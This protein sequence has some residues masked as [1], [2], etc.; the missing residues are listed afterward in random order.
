MSGASRKRKSLWD[1][2]TKEEPQIQAQVGEKNPWH[3]EESYSSL[4]PSWQGPQGNNGQKDDNRDL[5]DVV[6]TGR[7]C[8]GDKSYR[9]S[10]GFHAPGQQSLGYSHE[11]S[12]SQSHRYRR[13][14]S[15][16]LSKSRSRS[17]SSSRSRS[18][19]RGRDRSR[20]HS[21]GRSRDWGRGRSRSRSPLGDYRRESHRLNDNRSRFPPSSQLCRDYA[22]GKCRRGSQC[23]YLHQDNLNHKDGERLE[24]EQTDRWRSRQE[25]G[26][27]R[28]DGEKDEFLRNTGKPA[29]ICIDFLKGRCH[30]GSS[31]RYPHHDATGDNKDRSNKY[32]SSDHGYKRQPRKSTPCKYFLM[33][34]CQRDDC[35]FSHD[36]PAHGNLEGKPLDD[37]W[38]RDFDNMNKPL[39][40]S[41][42]GAPTSV[43][44]TA[45]N[46]GSGNTGKGSSITAEKYADNAWGHSLDENN[47]QW[48]GPKWSDVAG[49]SGSAKS[50]CWG[51]NNV[52][53]V[54]LTNLMNA[55]KH[56]SKWDQNLDDE[57]RMLGGTVWKDKTG[58]TYENASSNWGTGSNIVKMGVSLSENMDKSFDRE[59][60]P[61]PP[62]L[63]PQ[64]PYAT[65]KNVLEQK[66]LPGASGQ[67]LGTV[68]MHSVF[69]VNSQ[70]LQHHSKIGDSDD[71]NSVTKA[72]ISGNARHPN[73]VPGESIIQNAD[74]FGSLTPSFAGISQTQHGTS[75]NPTN[76]H[77]ID[78]N[79]PAQ[80]NFFSSNLQIQ[81]QI[82]HGES[83]KTINNPGLHQSIMNSE[84]VGQ[85]TKFP[86]SLTQILGN[87]QLPQ[88]YAALNPPN[89][90]ELVSSHPDS[91]SLPP[92]TTLVGSQHV[93][94][95]VSQEQ[96][97]PVGNSIETNKPS[98]SN[99]PPGFLL[100]RVEQKNQM[101]LERPSPSSAVGVDSANLHNNGC[102][103]DN[104]HRSP[105]LGQQKATE[106]SQIEEENKTED[107]KCKQEPEKSCQGNVDSDV[108]VED[109]TNGKDEKAMRLFKIALVEFVKEI[110][111]PKWKEG[112]MSREVHKTIV[113]KAVDKVTSTIQGANI[114]KTQ[115]KI[116]QYLSYSKTKLTKLVE[117][118]TERLLK[119]S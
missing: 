106:N 113:K 56:V 66:I 109:G 42:W 75:G 70:I 5:N 8:D 61:L 36:D 84:Q 102:P 91:V 49:V 74:N 43:L 81:A 7:T 112:Q 16:S 40:G 37:K 118:Y 15:R 45:V 48:N 51:D 2:D 69:P 110:L 68:V 105:E 85:I 95:A 31:C 80:Q 104:H 4:Q 88:L 93:P 54:D 101:L 27:N 58:E 115:E 1:R 13:S 34:K 119:S 24:K 10:P 9:M 89:S 35:R 78:L 64:T 98:N 73:L 111:K 32:S 117:A 53:N 6:G 97:D 29:M 79:G 3:G 50:S 52:E 72:N 82:Q 76:G 30:R 90:R 94:P 47:K 60:L 22:A 71:S 46:T 63:Q 100:N 83:A 25:D 23:R 17:R 18:R 19:G 108:K 87:G 103:D 65:S 99:Q 92:P 57:S 20:S 67:Q 96:Y 28:Y 38:G 114:P 59:N 14:R 26:R 77:N 86:A 39:N 21:R 116:D 107:E 62:H 11:K 33:G 12:W 41:E 55:E 44:D